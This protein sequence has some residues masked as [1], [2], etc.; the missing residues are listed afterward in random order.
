VVEKI[1]DPLMHLVRNAMDHGI[2]PAD[3]AP[4]GKPAQGMLRLNAFHDSGA[5]VITVQD[6]GGGLNRERILAKAVERGLVEAGHHMSDSEVYASSS[7]PVS[8]P[9]TRSPTCRAAVWGW[10][11][12]SA[13][14]PRCAARW[15]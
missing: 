7:S 5:I 10:M 3:C 9:P 12:S 1:G 14:S 8:P 11:W 15:I 4:R 13:T 2:E 6:D